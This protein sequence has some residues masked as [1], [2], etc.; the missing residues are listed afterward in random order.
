MAHHRGWLGARALAGALMASSAIP[1]TAVAQSPPIAVVLP[2]P[3]P[4]F[5]GKIGRTVEQSKAVFPQAVRAPAG[6]PNVLLVMTDDVGFGAS[7]T[8]GGPIAT[9]TFDRL[10]QHGLRYNRFH[11]AGICSPTRA[12][13]LTG[14]NHHSVGMG[15]FP[16]LASGFPGYT[17]MIP[18]SAAS[19]AEVLRQNGY[20]TS[21]FGKN[22]STPDIELGPTGPFD[23]W[24][25]GM[26]FEYFYGFNAYGVN[27]WSPQLYEGTK[28]VEPPTDDPN[29]HLD[30]DLADHAIRWIRTEKGVDPDK[31]FFAY[32]ATGTAHAPHHAPKDW[33]ARYE[34]QFDQGWDR[35]R[36]ETFARQKALGVIPHDAKLSPRPAGVPAWDSLTPDQ[37]RVFARMMEVY[38]AS[39]SYA[40]A[41]IGRVI[42][43]IA[44]TG[45]LDNTMIIFIE[46]DNGASAEGGLQGNTNETVALSGQI[47]EPISELVGRL[48]ELGGPMTYGH[49]PVGW[50]W[51]MDTPF[52]W[53]KQI[54]SH[55]GGTRNG[56]VV[57]WPRGVADEG[58]LRSQ[59][60]HVA[61]IFPTVLEAAGIQ[62]PTEVNGVAQKPLEGVSL[63][64][65]F[66]TPKAPERHTTQYFE[67]MGNRG[68]YKDGWFA[69][70]T[71]RR[72]PWQVGSKPPGNAADDYQWE[73]YD[74]RKDY[75]QAVNIAKANPAKLTELKAAFW[76]EAESHNVLPIDDSFVDRPAL[77]GRQPRFGD[78]RKSFRFPGDLTRLPS[79]V[80]PEIGRR[81]FRMTA[82]VDI[83]AGV[84]PEGVVA[85]LGGR[86]GGW[87]FLILD[88]R[89]VVVHALSEQ[90]RYKYRVATTEPL[91]TG[92]SKLTF[93]VHYTGERPGGPADVTISVDGRQVAT[94]RIPR[95]LP[96]GKG[97]GPETFDIGRDTG[98]P[99]VEDYAVPFAFKGEIRELTV[100]LE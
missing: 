68:I 42:D 49:Y 75:S 56:M 35:M 65:T 90:A 86:F 43:A 45:Q 77:V 82:D 95:T 79:E 81:S 18:K 53:T 28:P 13:L 74:L 34:G 12:A 20:S 5:T 25:T 15:L 84:K 7:S 57:S 22:H 36:E 59:F 72:V 73:L 63:A 38:A 44:Q 48:D 6:A 33:I 58:G 66:R 51:A 78:G 8:F 61:D 93:D 26:G 69:N 89:P 32:I 85:T 24:P 62:A 99:V 100:D 10:A 39:L 52:Q 4:A 50:A 98:T 67:L 60:G 14:R 54:A 16:N 76:R 21:M 37:K 96:S 80:A 17:G 23:R 47:D 2:A 31:P 71:P 91:K 11:T 41:Q 83:P 30:R 70:T 87:G 46:G 92:K 64:Y 19:M 55:F 3:E 9:P 1:V 27:Q 97:S 94:G 29:Y 88:G 40:D